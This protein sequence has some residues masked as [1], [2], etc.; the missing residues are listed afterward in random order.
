VTKESMKM[1]ATPREEDW[2]FDFAIVVPLKNPI[3]EP[4]TLITTK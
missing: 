4:V 3:S 2:A 1:R